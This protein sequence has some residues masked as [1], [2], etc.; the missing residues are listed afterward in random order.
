MRESRWARNGTPA[1]GSIGFGA[2]SVNG[3][4]RVPLPPTSTTASTPSSTR[5]SSHTGLAPLGQR[6]QSPGGRAV[7]VVDVPAQT[8]AAALGAADVQDALSLDRVDHHLRSGDAQHEP[9][10]AGQAVAEVDVGGLGVGAG[11]DVA[12]V[13]A[14]DR[15]PG[16]AADEHA[17]AVEPAGRSG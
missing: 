9:A 2:E 16:E 1:V 15:V 14:V 10:R 12:G 11:A 4:S 6:H 17:A 7:A 5:T 8:P 3:R 13:V